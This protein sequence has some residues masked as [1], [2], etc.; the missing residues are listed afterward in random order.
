MT[1]VETYLALKYGIS[2]EQNYLNA[3]G[4]T[5]WNWDN[6]K[7]FSNN[8]AGIGRDDQSSLFQKQSTSC[9][10][11]EQLVIGVNKIVNANA[12][13]TGQVN[14]GDYLIW[15][16]NGEEFVA[17]NSF[18]AA[19]E[20]L[21]SEKKWLMTVSGAGSNRIPTELKIDTKTFLPGKFPARNFYLVIDRSSSADFRP[22]NCIYIHPDTISADGI[23]TFKNIFWDTDGSGKD[24]FIFGFKHDLSS[25]LR[26]TGPSPVNV[27]P[28]VNP[29]GLFTFNVFPNPVSD[30]N[31][32]VTIQFEK[33]TDII[34]SLY[35]LSQKLI[36]TKKVSGQD[37]YQFSDRLNGKPSAYIL[38]LVTPQ[39]EYYRMI[40][41]Q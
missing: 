18:A 25:R 10:S 33:P 16:D 13:N 36:D 23:A 29:G 8:I 27:N 3:R 31:Y 4:K 12:E 35:D 19:N 30:G 21:L 24:N 37:F 22:E 9:T 17:S 38:Q 14:D 15:G 28:N 7:R 20:I 6:D 34:I 5:V 32:Q 39:E 2:L 11:S 26:S 41:L 1:K 40:I